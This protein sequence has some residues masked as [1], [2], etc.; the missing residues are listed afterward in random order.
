MIK[1]RAFNR[2]RLYFSMWSKVS[3]YPS[4]LS[5]LKINPRF[6]SVTD[7]KHETTSSDDLWMSRKQLNR[8]FERVGRQAEVV[9]RQREK[10]CLE[11]F[12]NVLNGSVAILL[13][14][15]PA[16]SLYYWRDP[17][18][19]TTQATSSVMPKETLIVSYSG[20][21]IFKSSFECYTDLSQSQ[22]V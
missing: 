11:W 18:A 5:L 9:D 6:V 10:D 21:E 12:S 8:N 22:C 2:V 17:C 15:E 7:T 13:V 1:M 16:E 4:N 3:I 19:E 14:V 20:V